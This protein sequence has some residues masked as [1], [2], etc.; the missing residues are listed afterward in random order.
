MPNPKRREEAEEWLRYATEDLGAAEVLAAPDAP[1]PK[2]ALFHAQQ[3]VEKALKALL[4]LQDRPYPLT[5]NLALLVDACSGT[6][7][8]LRSELAHAVWLTQYAVRFRYPGEPEEP[9]IPEATAG[10]ADARRVV[11][12]IRRRLAMIN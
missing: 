12:F 11:D 9:D 3:A 6:D 7:Q 8:Q 4:V 2:Q 1:R 5:H 10:L